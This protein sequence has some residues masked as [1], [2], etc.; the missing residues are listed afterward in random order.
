MGEV[1]ERPGRDHQQRDA[2]VQ[3]RARGRVDRPVAAGHPQH[4]RLGRGLGEHGE[5][6]LALP[7]LAHLRRGQRLRDLAADGVRVP[8]TGT[9]IRDDDEP[10][11]VR[12]GGQVGVRRPVLL[13]RLP[14]HRPHP[15]QRVGGEGPE[16]DAGEHVP[17]VVHPG[18]HAGVRDAARE[19][20]D[21]R[22]E[23]GTL[24]R[25]AGR[26]RRRRG[27]VAGRERARQRL[28]MQLTEQRDALERRTGP[29]DEQLRG[30]VRDHARGG[31]PRH[32][33]QRGPAVLLVAGRREHRRDAEPQQTVVRRPG[34]RRE[35][36]VEQRR[37]IAVQTTE[38]RVVR[39]GEGGH[40]R[41]LGDRARRG[42][43]SGGCPP[44]PRV[45]R[46]ARPS[47]GW[48]ENACASTPPRN[49]LAIISAPV[50]CRSGSR[51][52]GSA[53]GA[54]VELAQGAR[55]GERVAAQLRALGVRLVLPRPADRELEYGRGGG[56]QDHQQQRGEEVAAALVVV[57][58]ARQQ[59]RELRDVEDRAR[60]ARGDRTR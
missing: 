37:G 46:C 13:R 51:G 31:E 7:H 19:H 56:A 49:G 39:P 14:A 1:V 15:G 21:P 54:G 42:S 47:G 33:A 11:A 50:V 18:V 26:E 36:L 43:L 48:V 38:Q 52:S 45:G 60:D 34:E 22:A 24:Q 40:A 30:P 10:G 2:R 8:A 23:D 28:A 55:E 35:V 12:Q 20:P 32:P 16:R 6:V 27:R 59:P 9:G 4:R 17:G 58:A 53:R 3:R 5:D 41:T 29:A 57:R 44:S 25:D